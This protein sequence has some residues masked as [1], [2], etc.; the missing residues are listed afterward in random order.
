MAESPEDFNKRLSD[1]AQSVD[2]TLRSI[3]S[4]I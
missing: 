4:N 3:S 2:N 1:T